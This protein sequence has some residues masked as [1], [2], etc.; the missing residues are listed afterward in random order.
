MESSSDIFVC[1]IICDTFGGDVRSRNFNNFDIISVQLSYDKKTKQIGAIVSD[2][3]REIIS[4]S[5]CKH[6]LF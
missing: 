1:E 3:F 5:S 4:F 6:K 2:F